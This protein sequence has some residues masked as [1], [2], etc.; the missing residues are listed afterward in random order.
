M[1]AYRVY[2]LDSDNLVVRARLIEA[3]SDQEAINAAAEFRWPRWQLGTGTRLVSDN[4]RCAVE[5]VSAPA[6]E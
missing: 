3:G 1:K 5:L 4:G 2:A 6:A